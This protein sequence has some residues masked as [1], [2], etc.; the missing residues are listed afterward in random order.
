LDD[1]TVTAASSVAEIVP[2]GLLRDQHVEH[3]LRLEGVDAEGEVPVLQRY[4][5]V[6]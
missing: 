5:S 1:S 4:P 3:Q 6:M 2:D